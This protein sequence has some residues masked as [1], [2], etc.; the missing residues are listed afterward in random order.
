MLSRKL[1]YCKNLEIY[2]VSS[3][4]WLVDKIAS[5][6]SIIITF[7]QGYRNR[8]NLIGRP[9]GSYNFCGKTKRSLILVHLKDFYQ[10]TKSC[11]EFEL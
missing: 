4:S 10:F 9:S 5:F 6:S 1:G 3:L 2:A 11:H 7:F 8:N